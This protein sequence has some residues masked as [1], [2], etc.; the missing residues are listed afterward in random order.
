VEDPQALANRSDAWHKYSS[1]P[2]EQYNF[3]KRI[4]SQARK[5]ALNIS[6]NWPIFEWSFNRNESF[7]T[8]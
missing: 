7:E 8:Y 3:H 4:F 1:L 6:A 5:D 2:Q